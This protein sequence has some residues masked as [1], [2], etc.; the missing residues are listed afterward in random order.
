MLYGITQ[1]S[2]TQLFALMQFQ[3]HL[4]HL[5][6]LTSLTDA[7]AQACTHFKGERLGLTGLK[8]LTEKQAVLLQPI[9]DKIAI[10]GALEKQ[11]E[12]ASPE[13]SP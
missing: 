10:S 12:S 3:G 2:D 4:L 7:Q 8:S 6:G 5:G 11:V 1:L 9:L 13:T